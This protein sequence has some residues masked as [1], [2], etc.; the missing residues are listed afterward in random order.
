M[1]RFTDF[2]DD[3]KLPAEAIEQIAARTQAGAADEFGGRQIE[4]YHNAGGKVYC[5]LQGPDEEAI[6]KHHQARSIP[7]RR[8]APG[9]QPALNQR[10]IDFAPV[11]SGWSQSTKTGLADPGDRPAI[12]SVPVHGRAEFPDLDSP[13]LDRHRADVRAERTIGRISHVERPPDCS[14]HRHL[15]DAE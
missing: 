10:A 1:P 2:H 6:R 8:R 11:S 4:L 14:A 12:P 7:L 13:R 5:L 9:E 15:R 3:L